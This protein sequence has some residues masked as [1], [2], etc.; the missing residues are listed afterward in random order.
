LSGG[1]WTFQN[2]VR[3]GVYINFEGKGTVG[4][5]G[6]RGIM[7]MAL[8]LGWGAPKT[9]L[10]INAGDDVSEL[11]G[12]DITAASLLLVKEALKR[13]STVLLYRLNTGTK[14][15]V[16]TGLLTATAKYGGVRGNDLTV[17]IQVNID[18]SAKFDVQ[19]LLSGVVVDTQTV[20]D[21][22]GLTANDWIV[23][24]G[25]GALATTAGAPLVGGA[26]GTV[27]NQDHTDYL[28]A[29]ELFDFQT[30]ALPSTDS[31]LKSVYVAFANRLR[32]DEGRKIQI[33][34]ENYPSADYEGVI[35]VKNGVILSDGTTLTAAQATA[36]TAAATAG[37]EMNE[38][39]TY[40]AYDDAVDVGTRYTNSQIE[41]ALLAGE[42]V[43]TLNNGRPVVEQDI[44]TLTSF[45]PTKPK[46]FAKNRVIRVLDGIANDFKRTFSL[47]YI[48]KVNNNADGR[49]LFW[50]E[51]VTYLNTL[52][53][54]AAIQNFNAQTDVI[55]LPGDEVDSVYTEVNIQPVDSIEKIYMK[56]KVV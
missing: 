33:A 4:T 47:F 37:A 1:T 35:S 14:A 43:F 27:A 18:D 31:T 46:A 28:A 40:Q 9:V 5:V 45:T 6:Q 50:N 10:T 32:E 19:T 17:V 16:T 39:L 11:L 56:V 13:A 15:T 8:P 54:I 22:S 49:A 44:N 12:Y 21:I 30:M 41:A 36:W 34:V 7:T 53:G 24:S 3:P 25:T 20:A 23:W 38:S 42:F 26:D 48:G 52:Q 2:K 55:V 51:C 29:I